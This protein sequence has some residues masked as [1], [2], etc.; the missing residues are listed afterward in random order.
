MKHP[1]FD[2]EWPELVQAVYSHDM[3]EM[4]D[5]SRLP[6]I[7]NSYHAELERYLHIAG[8]SPLRIL[9]VGCA[10]G[11]LALLLAEAGHDVTA[12][13]LRREFLD[14]AQGRYESGTIRFIQGN[15]LELNLSDS[16]DLVFSNQILEHLVYPVELIQG[17]ARLLKSGGRVVATT[18]NGRYLK[19]R[20][21]SFYELGD[22]A[23]YEDRQ[24]FSDGD[25]H[26]FAYQPE[27]LEDVFEQAGLVGVDV[28]PY[29]TPWISGHLKFRYLHGR[30]PA[31]LLRALDRLTLAAVGVR[32]R[33][34][35][36]LMALG[37]KA[38]C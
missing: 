27:E 29:A 7:F 34:A 23:Q 37:R 22:V 17:L 9:D 19:N 10:Q 36:Q 20:L 31:A 2:P 35:Y 30:V 18:P 1:V 38:S 26:F 11:T 13:D 8:D 4:W 15:A 24:F 25:G 33:W 6:H 32:S 21:P 5:P 16:F 14:Y 28:I 12:L 3:A